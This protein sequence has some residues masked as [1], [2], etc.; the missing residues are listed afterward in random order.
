MMCVLCL[1]W[2]CCSLC[3]FA[4]GVVFYSLLLACWVSVVVVVV[5]FILGCLL[6]CLCLVCVASCLMVV[7]FVV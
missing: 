1:L 5:L 4:V 6:P 3:A 7:G 2:F